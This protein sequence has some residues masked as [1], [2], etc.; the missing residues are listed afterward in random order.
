MSVKSKRSVRKS[1]QAT[2]NMRALLELDGFKW[3]SREKKDEVVQKIEDEIMNGADVNAPFVNADVVRF[4]YKKPE[5]LAVLVK[6][7]ANMNVIP[8]G[9]VE[10]IYVDAI[11]HPGGDN[12]GVVQAILQRPVDLEK[13]Y[14][15]MGSTVLM[16]AL[17]E[18][19]PAVA[20]MLIDAGAKLTAVDNEKNTV[21]HYAAMSSTVKIYDLILQ[22]RLNANAQDSYGR[23]PLMLAFDQYLHDGS[24][25]HFEFMKRI[26]PFTDVTL[27]NKSGRNIFKQID[28]ALENEDRD[29]VENIKKMV[30]HALREEV[31]K[32]MSV[33]IC[34]SRYSDIKL[35]D[36]IMTGIATMGL[37]TKGSKRVL[38]KMY[39]ARSKQQTSLRNGTFK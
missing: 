8:H 21:L 1:P 39:K 12:I 32:A 30:Q 18:E 13:K 17:A 11:R 25:S 6:H 14:G 23:T 2:A 10:P 5:R 9:M 16:I 38:T 19:K 28:D 35:P 24:E 29:D 37:D 26:A 31:T 22:Y 15:Q 36:E 33:L 3:S 7:G 27:T 20:K 4:L 34:A